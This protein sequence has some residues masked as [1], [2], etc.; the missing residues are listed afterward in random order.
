MLNTVGMQGKPNCNW[1]AKTVLIKIVYVNMH[2]I[3][4]STRTVGRRR[5]PALCTRLCPALQKPASSERSLTCWA[6]YQHSEKSD[7]VLSCPVSSVF[8]NELILH[9]VT[10]KQKFTWDEDELKH[11]MQCHDILLL[12]H[13]ITGDVSGKF[14]TKENLHFYQ[15]GT[16]TKTTCKCK[17][18]S[19]SWKQK[20]WKV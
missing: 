7:I 19:Q 16:E 9:V 10:V 11:K 20:Q 8:Q 6:R 13:V 1:I 12:W 2:F 15:Q 5:C 4:L 17:K 14:V 3:R 18:K